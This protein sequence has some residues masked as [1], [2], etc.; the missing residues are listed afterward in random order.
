[1]YTAQLGLSSPIAIRYPRGRGTT[2]DWKGPFNT[3]DIGISIELKRG[4]RLAI[5]SLGHVGNMVCELLNTMGQPEALGHYNMRF[6]KPLDEAQLAFIFAHYEHVITIEDGC[7]AGGFGSAVLEYANK[8]HFQKP[9][10]TL[11]VGDEFLEHG[12][13]DELHADA[14]I[15]AA[16]LRDHINTFLHAH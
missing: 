12:S 4:S 13:I 7:I 6:A 9:I 11:G 15:D 3:V 5:L 1:M 2:P 10:K 14:G 8:M 16:A